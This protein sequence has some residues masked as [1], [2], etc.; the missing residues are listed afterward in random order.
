MSQL[1]KLDNVT[2]AATK[3]V[4]GGEL[5]MSPVD[6]SAVYKEFPTNASHINIKTVRRRSDVYRKLRKDLKES[7]KIKLVE[8]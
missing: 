5:A 3:L 2:V 7:R 8:R 4:G 6:I 1:Y